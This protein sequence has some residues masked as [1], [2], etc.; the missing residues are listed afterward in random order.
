MPRGHF[1]RQSTGYRAFMPERLPPDPAVIL[2]SE[3]IHLLSEADR[4]LGRLDGMTL[5]LPN[6]DMFV[7]MYVRQEA[8]LSSQI[9]G[10]QASL[11]DV[12]EYEN[13]L[14]GAKNPQDLEEVFN[15]IAAMNR[16]L[17]R[18]RELPLS[19]RLIREIH[20]RLMQGVRG[21]NRNP[22]EFRT[23]Q[24]WIGPLGC[25][26]AQASY[27]PP[28]PEQMMISLGNLEEFLHRDSDLIPFLVKVGIVH[29]QFET[30]HPFLDG[31][32]RIGRLLITFLLCE[33]GIMKWPCLY[34]SHY[35]KK[36]KSEYYTRLQDTR[37]KGDWEGWVKFFLRGVSEV[38]REA[39]NTASKILEIREDTQQRVSDGL[40]RAGAGNALT[41]LPRLFYRPVVSVQQVSE[42]IQTTYATANYLVS[43]LE[44]IGILTEITGWG[45][46]RKFRFAPYL[47]L[48]ID[49]S[50]G[51]P[52]S[53]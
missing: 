49:H 52:A 28:P 39:T 23:S 3:M 32:G 50:E 41:L 30:I 17:D 12:L 22:G 14:Q 29:A 18:L 36:Y 34:I 27:I 44:R 15:Y 11:I 35:F 4:N 40:T 47:D 24:N 37:E 46:N 1:Q 7:F 20:D 51:T 42:I 13:D 21:Q 8:V 2:D 10:T 31:N 38:A 45:R 6:P 5:T 53:A 33:A 9:E 25:T 16:G 43:D 19:L 26:L 48:F